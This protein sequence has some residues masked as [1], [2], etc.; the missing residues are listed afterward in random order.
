MICYRAH[1]SFQYLFLQYMPY[2]NKINIFTLH[3]FNYLSFKIFNYLFKKRENLAHTYFSTNASAHT[4][5]QINFSTHTYLKR[6][7]IF[8]CV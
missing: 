6:K 4:L 7:K 3:I 5:V 2:L 1:C 8:F